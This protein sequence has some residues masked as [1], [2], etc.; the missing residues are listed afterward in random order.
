MAASPFTDWFAL[1]TVFCVWLAI[2]LLHPSLPVQIHTIG[3]SSNWQ[4]NPVAAR[5]HLAIFPHVS[6]MLGTERRPTTPWRRE[7]MVEVGRKS[8]RSS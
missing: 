1:S 7:K 8:S 4:D 2:L 5:T 3:H 6:L